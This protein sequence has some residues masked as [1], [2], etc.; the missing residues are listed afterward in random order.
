MIAD[1]A[2]NKSLVVV[3]VVASVGADLA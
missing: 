1:T 2:K 3:K